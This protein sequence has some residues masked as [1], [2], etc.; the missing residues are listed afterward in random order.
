VTTLLFIVGMILLNRPAARA[1]INIPAPGPASK[2]NPAIQMLATGVQLA[3]LL[4]TLLG[5]ERPQTYLL[6]VQNNHELRATGGFITAVGKVTV[7]KGRVTSLEFVD[8]YDI[9]RDDVD[10]PLAPEAVKRFMDIEILFLRDS[11]WSPDF[12]TTAQFARSLYA[13]DAG[14]RVDGVVS[15]D[16]R[17][18]ELLVGALAPL[19]VPGAE[20]PL[21]GDNVMEQLV[22]FWDQPPGTDINPEIGHEWW[23]QRKDFMPLIAQSAMGRV[24]SGSFNPLAL[25]NA[26]N[27]ALNERAVQVWLADPA[28]AELLAQQGWDGRLRPIAG[29]D[30]LALVD[31]NM[32]YNKVNA[33]L[34]HEVDYTVEW[35]SDPKAGAKATVA[36]TYTHPLNVVD[37]GCSPTT[38]YGML[39]TYT[40]MTERCYF[41]YVRLYVPHGSELISLEGVQED[42]VSSQLGE[43]GTQV[44]A[45]YF[46]MKPGEQHTVTFTYRLPAHITP[47]NY[48]LVVQR[49][50][51]AAPLPL[52]LDIDDTIFSTTLVDG[53]MV[54][55][56]PA[57]PA[58]TAAP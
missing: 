40:E 21:T 19:Q 9:A 43:R 12:P 39:V 1:E 13:Q 35:P 23:L 32:G 20:V 6:L 56:A 54:W 7:D 25:L 52:H 29:A 22:K 10:H 41:G 15:V 44:F 24:Q 34:E 18:V 42:S 8:S 33:V 30:Y 28:A 11:N 5:F 51:G 14:V 57:L 55:P 36:I 50:S 26:V 3:P 47:Q 46:S 48:Q 53:R 45:G 2:G 58:V 49:Q 4:P 31:T 27:A 37:E 38:G 16:M 17:A